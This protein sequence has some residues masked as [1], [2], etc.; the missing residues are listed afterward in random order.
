MYTLPG[1]RRRER[2]RTTE[3][4]SVFDLCSRSL[5]SRTGVRERRDLSFFLKGYL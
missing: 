2:A 5:E 1:R 4:F 3:R